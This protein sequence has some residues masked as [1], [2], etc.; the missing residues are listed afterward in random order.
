MSYVIDLNSEPK[1]QKSSNEWTYVVEKIINK[2]RTTQQILLLW[3]KYLPVSGNAE[4]YISVLAK[5]EDYYRELN[6]KNWENKNG[7]YSRGCY[8]LLKKTDNRENCIMPEEIP[9]ELMKELENKLIECC[10]F[11][12]V[13]KWK[14]AQ[15][16]RDLSGVYA[17]RMLITIKTEKRDYVLYI[18]TP[19]EKE[20]GDKN[21]IFVRWMKREPQKILLEEYKDAYAELTE[22]EIKWRSNKKMHKSLESNTKLMIAMLLSDQFLGQKIGINIHEPESTDDRHRAVDWLNVFYNTLPGRML[23]DWGY[24]INVEKSKKIGVY[25]NAKDKQNAAIYIPLEKIELRDSTF[26]TIREAIARILF[27]N[28]I[29]FIVDKLSIEQ[30][31]NMSEKELIK[32][33]RDQIMKFVD[34]GSK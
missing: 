25:N 19:Y 29:F 20:I 22:H 24:G 13:Q 6:K 31:A 30:Q 21:W 28:N 18:K 26:C 32:Y 3:K 9:L 34:K 11:D 14:Q 8:V 1:N 10:F 7:T 15:R 12:E 16:G 33:I 17:P 2:D 27:T 4:K 23:Y 5:Y